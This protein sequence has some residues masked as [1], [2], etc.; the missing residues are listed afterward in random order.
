MQTLL[1]RSAL[2]LLLATPLAQAQDPIVFSTAPTHGK[3]D[4]IRLYTP[5]IDYLSKATGIP[6][7]LEAA[8]N[9]IEYSNHMRAGHYDMLFDG[10]H[11]SGWRIDN[12]D[13]VA[14]A[15]LP[16]Q[17]A[18]VVIGHNDSTVQSMQ[19]L[20][21]G[22]IKVCALASPNMLTL[23]FLS[24]FPNPVRQPTLLG[25]QG[26]AELENCLRS[27][28]G[29]AAVI[30]DG[31]W[32]NMNQAG[33][34]LLASPQGAYPERTFTIHS[35]IDPEHRDRIRQA[36]LS[37]AGTQ[38]FAALLKRFNRDRLIP[39]GTEEYHG[40]GQLLSPIWGFH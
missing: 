17:I 8:D 33:L 21:R 31:Q 13:H 14:L 15:R 38:A 20:E 37:E 12:Q 23:A 16:G 11:L 22:N 19:E 2:L 3:E 7:V 4:T 9:F 32:K 36:L 28:H 18:I 35:R 1:K 34:K 30:R 25:V 39:A 24:H 40:L 5:L 27:G 6:F 29:D 26:F 10:P